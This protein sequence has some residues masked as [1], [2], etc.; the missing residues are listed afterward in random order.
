LKH[1]DA[2]AAPVAHAVLTRPGA[3]VT[4][5]G[6]V[7]EARHRSAQVVAPGQQVPQPMRERQHPLPHGDVRQHVVHKVRGTFGHSTAAAAWAE[8]APLAREGD[9]PLGPAG[10]APEP[11]KAAGQEAA[12]QERVE[13]VLDESREPLAVTQTPRFDAKRLDVLP[14]DDVEH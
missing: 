2:A 5:H 13:F 11:G 1:G 10:V 4:F 7:Q 14:H 3:Q 8:A 9:E 6:A 12:A